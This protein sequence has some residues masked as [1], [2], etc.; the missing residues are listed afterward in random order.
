M[1]WHVFKRD[2]PNTWPQ[3]NCPMLVCWTNNNDYKLYNVKWDDEKQCYMHDLKKVM[4]Y[5]GDVFYSYIGCIPY[6]QKE[7]HPIKCGIDRH[8]CV[9]Y[10]NGYCLSEKKC[11]GQEVA[12]EYMLGFKS[13]VGNT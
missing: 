5:E 1:N 8:L 9:H 7:C 3:V 2:D 12:T 10:D 6:I 13:V 4:F 11:K